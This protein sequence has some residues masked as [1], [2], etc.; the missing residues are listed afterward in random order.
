MKK[1][2][3]TLLLV[4]VFLQGRTYAQVEKTNAI[5]LS[6][7][8]GKL[9]RQDVN[10]SPFIFYPTSSLNVSFAYEH[11]GKVFQRVYTRFGNYSDSSE[12]FNYLSDIEGQVGT[13]PHTFSIL[14][15]NY[16]LGFKAISN[17][18]L[19]LLVGGQ[20]RNQLNVGDYNYGESGIGYYN[21]AFGLDLWSGLDYRL[22]K[23]HHIGAE[24]SLP[25]VSWV[26]RSPY[27]GQDDQYFENVAKNK[28]FDSIGNYIADGE[29]QSW[30]SFQRFDFQVKYRY[31]I[32]DKWSLKASYNLSMNFSN[33]PQSY[34][35][36]E[37][38]VLFGA[39]LNF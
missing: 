37:N 20:L 1:I 32:S 24:L 25:V 2:L 33:I 14:D 31:A 17:D 39:Q 36:I 21:F 19:T 6:Y 13:L 27:L 35:S 11:T 9:K 10:F 23:K 28:T 7:G 38:L 8:I 3:I 29:L 12:P 4:T 26:T 5:S 34:T 16:T 22:A 15:L 30:G 18:K